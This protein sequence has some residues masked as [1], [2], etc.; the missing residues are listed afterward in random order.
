M[1]GVAKALLLAFGNLFHPRML[2]LMLWPVLVALALW[3]AALWI[4][5]AQ[6]VL[7]LVE[8]MRRLISA[9]TF[10]IHWDLSVAL[11]L[12]AK[13]LIFIGFVPLV[14]LTA[15]LILGVAGM[16]VMVEHVASRKYPQLE[17]RRG[18]SVVGSVWN[19]LVALAGLIALFVVSLP[20]WLLPP[21]WPLIPVAVMGWVNQRILRYDAIAEHADAHEMR[22]LFRRRRGAL[23]L[24][25][26]TLALIAFVPVVGFFATMVFALAFIHFCLAELAQQRNAPVEGEVLQAEKR[27]LE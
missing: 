4:F 22:T 15:L 18:G 10:T 26:V 24:L 16:P 20:F 3:L 5:G 23:Y 19:S 17:R 27:R 1:N 6:L 12:A 11:A 2:W 8:L 25:G 7:A 9:A 21:L 14:Q 13:V